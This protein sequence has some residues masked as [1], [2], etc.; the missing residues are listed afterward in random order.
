V[1]C[2]CIYYTT[3]FQFKAIKEVKFFDSGKCEKFKLITDLSKFEKWDYNDF[4]I[5]VLNGLGLT[6]IREALISFNHTPIKELLEVTEE[7]EQKGEYK[8]TL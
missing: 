1:L 5:E 7:P 4:K 3:K 8:V 2:E 6:D